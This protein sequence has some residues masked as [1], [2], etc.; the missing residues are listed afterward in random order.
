MKK[1]FGLIGILAL[2][3][4]FLFTI[5]NYA[6]SLFFVYKYYLLVIIILLI[7]L[8]NYKII[9]RNIFKIYEKKY[10]ISKKFN[11]LKS[12]VSEYILSCNNFN[13]YVEELKES[14][15]KLQSYNYGTS[16]MND[17]SIFNFTRSGWQNTLYDHKIHYC[18][19]NVCA[20]AKRQPIKY[21]CKYFNVRI[22]EESLSSLEKILNDFI[23]VEEGKKILQIDR[24]NLMT[25]ISSEIPFLIKKFSG[26]RI[27]QKLGF[28]N[29][30]LSDKYVPIFTFQYISSAGN[31]SLSCEIPLNVSNLNNLIIY[32]ND[33][34]TLQKTI[35]YQR[36]LMTSALREDIKKRDNYKC[37]ICHLGISNEPN[38]LLEIDH[39]IPLSK[40]GLTVFHNLQ[41]LCWRCNRSKGVKIMNVS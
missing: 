34:L 33:L 9:L 1:L 17:E 3:L 20:N 39:I 10:F 30:D 19:A 25:K 6:F 14:S 32:I 26:D 11:Y 41:T 12:N 15:V 5:F 37:C 24:N 28:D 27:Y 40:G 36:S 35:A 22:Q 2:I 31:S 21:F 13:S 29:I 7:I 18:S 8:V 16:N 23:S 4:Y 38:L